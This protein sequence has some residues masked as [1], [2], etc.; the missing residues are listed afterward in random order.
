MVAFR[1]GAMILL[2]FSTALVTPLPKYLHRT[3]TGFTDSSEEYEHT[4]TVFQCK[5]L[6]EISRIEL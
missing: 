4:M 2:M 1:A 6:L 3:E 5:F